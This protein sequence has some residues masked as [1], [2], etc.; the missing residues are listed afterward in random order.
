MREDLMIIMGLTYN[1][2]IEIRAEELGKNDL[3]TCI[4]LMSNVLVF[5]G[6]ELLFKVFV[7]RNIKYME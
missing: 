4:I 3:K 1:A 6:F 7:R 5:Y 2:K